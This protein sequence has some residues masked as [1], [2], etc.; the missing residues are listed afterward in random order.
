MIIAVSDT[1]IGYDKCNR[2]DFVRFLD[3]V[4]LQDDVTDLV[5]AGDKTALG[6]E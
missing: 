3:W 6:G 4:A 5:L 2:A 1:H